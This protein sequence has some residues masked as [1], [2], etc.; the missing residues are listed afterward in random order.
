MSVERTFKRGQLMNMPT[1]EEFLSDLARE[2]LDPRTEPMNRQPIVK[3]YARLMQL[4]EETMKLEAIEAFIRPY[5]DHCEEHNGVR[6]C[7]NCG[8]TPPPKEAQP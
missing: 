5:L 4:R 2:L 8:L 7:K 1:P 3:G 6:C